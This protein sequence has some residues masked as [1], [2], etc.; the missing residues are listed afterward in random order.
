MSI[1]TSVK[2]LD[3]HRIMDNDLPIEDLF[4]NFSTDK[5]PL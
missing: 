4:N 5:F 3:I 2:E 1:S